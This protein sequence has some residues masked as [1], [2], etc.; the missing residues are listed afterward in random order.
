ML[1]TREERTS[2]SFSITSLPALFLFFSVFSEIEQGKGIPT[3][4][5][6][7]GTAA[8][9]DASQGSRYRGLPG[10]ENLVLIC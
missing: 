6:D 7:S 9:G 8:G 2:P 5:L 4:P 10:M 1:A 3:S